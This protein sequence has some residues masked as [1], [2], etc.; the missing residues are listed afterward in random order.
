[1]PTISELEVRYRSEVAP[2]ATADATALTAVAQGMDAVEKATERVDQKLSRVPQSLDRLK[3][4]LDG[5]E[6][7]T[8]RITAAQAQH[9]RRV[10][11]ATAYYQRGEITLQQYQTML[12]RSA[13]LLD[14]ATAKAVAHGQAYEQ[15]FVPAQQQAAQA[16]QGAAQAADKASHA[17]RGLG[18]QSIDV[19]QQLASGAPVMITLIQQGSQVAQQSA[20][21]GV[22]LGTLARGAASVVASFAPAI[23]AFGSLAAAAGG[24]WAVLS[25]ASELAAQQ[26]ALSV[27]IQGVGRS[28]EL[29][30]GQ[31]QTYVRQLERQGVASGDAL[32]SVA[33]LARNGSLSSGTINRIVS[34]GPDAAAALGT[35]VPEAMERLA[36]A[37]RGGM[38]AIQ[39]LSDA[40]NLLSPAEEANIR[41]MIEHGDRATALGTV[42]DKLQAQVGGLARDALSPAEQAMRNMSNAWNGLID[43]V[44]TSDLVVGAIERIAAG[45]KAISGLLGPGAAPDTG[46]ASDAATAANAALLN[47]QLALRPGSRS[48]NEIGRRILSTYGAR[49]SSASP[50]AS[51]AFPELPVPD[52]STAQIPLPPSVAATFATPAAAA[53]REVDRAAAARAAGAPAGQVRVLTAELERYQQALAAIPRGS[54][55]WA[56]RAPILQ[57]A[58]AA[59]AKAIEDATK[60]GEDHLSGLEKTIA[61]YDAQTRAAQA[62]EAAHRSG[63]DAVARVRAQQEAEAKVISDGLI[64]GTAKY[65]AAMADLTARVLAKNQADAGAK[66]AE[67]LAELKDATEAQMR[68]NAAYDGTE[69]SVT[70]AQNAEKAASDARRANLTPGTIAYTERVRDLAA[71]YDQSSAAAEVF[72]QSQASVQAV[73]SA[74]ET[75]ADRIGQ[76]LVD[77]FINGRDAAVTMASVARAA[78]ASLATDAARL[79]VIN[80]LV[81][82]VLGTTRPTLWS[83]LGTLAGGGAAS[84]AGGGAGGLFGSLGN[85]IS[86]GRLSDSLGLTNFGSQLSGIGRF[87]GLSGENGIFSSVGSLLNTQAWGTVHP[88]TALLDSMG[89]PAGMPGTGAP[90]IGELFGGVGLGFSAGSLLGG[91][92]QRTFNRTGPAPTIGA[93]LGAG[94]GAVIG[95]F[96][97]G[98]GTLLGGLAGGLFGGGTGSL[99]GPRPATPFSATGLTA[100]ASGMLSVGRTFSQIVDTTAEVAALSDQVQR[101]NSI[102]AASGTRIANAVSTDEFNQ[103]RIVGANSGQWLNFGQGGGRP[104]SLID[105]FGELRFSSNDSAMNSALSGRA[106]GSLDDLAKL[107]DQVGKATSFLDNLVPALTDL[108]ERSSQFSDALKA[109]NDTYGEAIAFARDTAQV[110]GISAEMADRLRQAETD[111]V[112]AREAASLKAVDAVLESVAA[113]LGAVPAQLKDIADTFD[114]ALA[115]IRRSVGASTAVTERLQQAELALVEARDRR[116]AQVYEEAGRSI[117]DYDASLNVRYYNVTADQRSA[118]IFAADEQARLERQ[119]LDQTL[120]RQ[121][122]EAIRQTQAYAD[123]FALL[124]RTLAAE[125]ASLVEQLDAVAAREARQIRDAATGSAYEAVSS[126][127][128]YARGLAFSAASPLS[129]QARFDLA[130]RQFDEVSGAATAGDFRSI[131]GLPDTADTL[132][133]TAREIYGSGAN[134]VAVFER[135]RQAIEQLANRDA[136]SLIVSAIRDAERSQTEALVNKLDQMRQE[137]VAVKAELRQMAMAPRAA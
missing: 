5:T 108:T 93:G 124:N 62:M 68:I 40:F 37:A 67:R 46:Y 45:L 3:A 12:A 23:L 53:G 56:A 65:A 94:A 19:F 133:A 106:F 104:G 28:A 60:K 69:A 21:M 135:V 84:A 122:G 29:S 33:G 88:G 107:I 128:A 57:E 129:A 30:A 6:A 130:S 25:R 118:R 132:L 121:W 20:A 55:E 136:E 109:V 59:T 98:V 79:G 131:Q 42:F 78:F 97:P 117:Y 134:Y 85:A 17:L 82:G 103:A 125:R 91:V 90:T 41:R 18:I 38:D 14:Q 16:M 126:I 105:A 110:Q 10:A 32:S 95:S 116:T 64:P 24:A 123:Q 70:K 72:R 11:D 74:I 47:E 71:A 137:L 115:D 80:P 34:L 9:E 102:L 48:I 73:L 100:D 92:L 114:A 120:V 75:A 89:I 77:G 86:L 96:I 52:F 26:R 66:T 58:I 13:V 50:L 63:A 39:D 61:A 35:G 2:K 99:I 49:A 51:V 87:L 8:R 15:R 36:R 101:V 54:D 112:A 127:G 113:P 31:M 43:R 83:G 119:A 111:L 44:A 1:M 4:S 22:S 7:A 27:A 81:N 76:S